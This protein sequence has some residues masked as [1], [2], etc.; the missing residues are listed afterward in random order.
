MAAR[1]LR[2]NP[3][4]LSTLFG[5]L[6]GL[7]PPIKHLFVPQSADD[8]APLDFLAESL[9]SVGS[10]GI[11][12]ALMVIGASLAR[13]LARM[14]ESEP[15]RGEGAGG[16]EAEAMRLSVV[17]AVLFGRLLLM[18]SI[19]VLLAWLLIEAG[20][21]PSNNKLLQFL[22]TI[23]NVAPTASTV[24]IITHM[25]DAFPRETARIVLFQYVVALLTLPMFAAV[26][27]LVVR[28]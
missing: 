5:I 15:R 13:G 14:S 27:L 9:L 7:I 11:P 3:P 22:M 4:L 20:A 21:V 16:A 26:G 6:C 23:N 12:V 2:R 19:S 17:L 10:A 28:D 1:Q 24:V 18:A 25:R 8:T